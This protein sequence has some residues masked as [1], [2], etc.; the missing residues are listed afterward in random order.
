MIVRYF[1]AELVEKEAIT[2]DTLPPRFAKWLDTSSSDCIFNDYQRK[3][4][5]RPHLRRCPWYL[6]LRS[7]EH[8]FDNERDWKYK[9]DRE[10][11]EMEARGLQTQN[12]TA[13]ERMLE[14]EKKKAARAE[15]RKAE[16]LEKARQKELAKKHEKDER[17]QNLRHAKIVRQKGLKGA[18]EDEGI[19]PS[20]SSKPSGSQGVTMI[21]SQSLYSIKTKTVND[22]FPDVLLFNESA[23]S[24]LARFDSV[25]EG[26]KPATWAAITS[27]VSEHQGN[28]RRHFKGSSANVA[29]VDFVIFYVP[30]GLPVPGFNGGIDV[31]LWNTLALAK[32]EDGLE[33]S[34][35]VK[36]AFTFADEWLVTTELFWYFILTASSFQGK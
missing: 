12:P 13:E 3:A 7:G 26:D 6:E 34:P 4:F 35:W 16:R 11:E 27:F 2:E 22:D 9:C 15:A 33:E 31:P 14:K 8:C 36:V 32:D 5:G 17:K 28:K 1:F 29:A 30:E 25:T 10:T 19:S 24:I 21:G 20:A 18:L 23:D